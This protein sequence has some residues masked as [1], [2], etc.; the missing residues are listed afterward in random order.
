MNHDLFKYLAIVVG[1]L[2]TLPAFAAT[3]SEGGIHAVYRP[4]IAFPEFAPMWRE[5]W[6]WT[7]ESGEKVRYGYEGMPL[8]G[9]L[10]AYF[11]NTSGRPLEVK[12]VF[13]QGVSLAQGVASHGR[14]EDL[15]EKGKYPSSIRFSKLPKEQIDTLI[16]AGTPVWWKVEPLV[17]PPGGMGEVTIRLRRDPQIDELRIGVPVSA[18]DTVEM[19]LRAS[20]RQARFFSISFSPELDKAYTYLR[21]PGGKGIAPAKLL[22][23]GKDVTRQSRI[24]ADERV[25]TAGAVIQLE[26]PLERGT[27]HFF[28]AEYADGTV[29]M[30]RIGAWQLGYLY[31]MWGCDNSRGTPEEIGPRFLRDLELHNINLH[32]SHCPGAANEFMRS[33]AGHA[34]LAQLG[35]QKMHHWIDNDHPPAFYFMTD[36]PDAADFQSKMLPPEERLGS[37]A[38]WLVEWGQILRRRDT[39]GTPLLLNI[40]NTF[41]PE[42]WYMYTQLSDIP[43]AD[44]YFQEAVQSVWNSDP[45]NMSA[46]LKPTYVYGVGK[47]YQSAGA[48]HPMHL[49]LHTCIFDF[50]PPET[51]YRGPTPEEK[52]IEVY[53]ALA[54]GAKQISYWWYCQYDQYRGVGHIEQRPLWT[55]IGLLGAETRTVGDLIATACP[56]DVPVRAPR[57]VWCRSLLVGDDTMILLVV[58][59]NH[60]SDRLGTV[61]KTRQK[62]DIRVEVPAWLASPQVFEVNCDGTQDVAATQSGAG[63]DLALGTLDLTRM[64]VLTKDA[65]LRARL[66]QEYDAKYAENVRKLK[67]LEAN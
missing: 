24:V 53:Y 9:Y 1:L 26:R 7:D 56:A 36:E 12:D 41:K 27:H 8:G 31:G 51:P 61:Y 54:S 43:C 10:F 20:Q 40:D 33:E 59:D 23:D 52:R 45:T 65:G 35:I 30:A 60:A 13:L 18:S 25:E 4:D 49:I 47:I 66:Q 57:M 16:A 42:N 67:Q 38:Q 17:I 5:G 21:H 28:R 62:T 39:V 15:S 64:I 55:E 14:R 29:A 44:P 50:K 11:H 34:M 48:P 22:V 58:N 63:V 6:S 2:A 19:N 46:Y 37:L 32:M 3:K